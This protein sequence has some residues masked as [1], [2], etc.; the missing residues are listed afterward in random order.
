MCCPRERVTGPPAYWANA[1]GPFCCATLPPLPLESD[2]NRLLVEAQFDDEAVQ[3]FAWLP[4]PGSLQRRLHN[5]RFRR[6]SYARLGERSLA[7]SW[8]VTCSTP[9]DG[10]N[11]A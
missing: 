6:R 9:L 2:F 7:A 8:Y 5:R 4:L 11:G 1:D 3:G 10:R